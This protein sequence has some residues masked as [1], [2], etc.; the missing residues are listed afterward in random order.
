MTGRNDASEQ[1]TC[2]LNHE[3]AKWSLVN[4]GVTVRKEITITTQIQAFVAGFT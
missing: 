1:Y 4:A 3:T 2:C